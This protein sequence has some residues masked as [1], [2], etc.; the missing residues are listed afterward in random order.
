MP[1]LPVIANTYR[2][3]LLW[4]HADGSH[5]VNVIHVTLSSSTAA[6]IF[7]LL[8]SNVD[9]ALWECIPPNASI[10]QVD[11]TPLDGTTAT[12]SFPTGSPAKWS[13]GSGAEEYIP[14]ASSLVKLTTATR[15][16]SHRGRIFLPYV[17]EGNQVNGT[18]D[19][20][21]VATW[22]A[23][24]TEFLEDLGGALVVASYKLSSVSSVT[25]VLCENK[26]ATQRRRQSRNRG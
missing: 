11:I 17:G 14:Q 24:W 10:H 7:T 16:R 6:S 12:Q 4:Q 9:A 25:S 22:Q 8:D 2:C 13:G 21:Q 20:G 26:T 23:S 3:A 19:A 1:P 18:L 5:A 15:G